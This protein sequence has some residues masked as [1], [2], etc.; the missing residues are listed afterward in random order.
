MSKEKPER[1]YKAGYVESELAHIADNPHLMS[2]TDLR[3]GISMIAA[4]L[5]LLLQ[6][7]RGE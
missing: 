3:H 1:I 2:S 7:S 5:L 6:E 4:G